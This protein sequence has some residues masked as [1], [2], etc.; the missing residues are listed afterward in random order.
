MGAAHRDAQGCWV[1][2]DG[3]W[4]WDGR[5][6]QPVAT[7]SRPVTGVDPSPPS[8][9]HLT[10]LEALITA[11]GT[12]VAAGQSAPP[13][14]I[15]PAWQ[16]VSTDGGSVSLAPLESVTQRA[17]ALRQTATELTD[18]ATSLQSNAERC[19]SQAGAQ[20]AGRST[21]WSPPAQLGA[22]IDEALAAAAAIAKAEE[23]LA[24]AKAAQASA[25]FFA[26]RHLHHEESELE[27]SEARD[28]TS[29]QPV[30]AQIG[31]QAPPVTLPEADRLRAQ[32]SAFEQPVVSIDTQVG[33][34]TSQ[35]AALEQ[36][37]ERRQ[38]A[39][40]SL[41]FDAPYEAAR[42]ATTGPT[43][44]ESQLILK[45]GEKSYLSTPARLARMVTRTQYVGGSSGV[46]IPI[47]HTGIRYRVGSF[48]GH[49]VQSQSLKTL[50]S[51][52]LILTN[53]RVAYV[54]STK[55]VAT[56]LSKIMHVA[57][58]TD[59]LSIA[60]EGRENSDWYLTDD[61][62]HFVFLLNWFLEHGSAGAG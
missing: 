51:G 56:P 30:L 61:P 33:S 54:G 41:G 48:H 25:G 29:V 34:A 12:Q 15:Q 38:Q 10:V 24:S 8:E 37:A 23:D 4:W 3:Q 52:V 6:W 36:E 27:S 44:I 46:S 50:D 39:I 18:Q 53:Q 58:Y 9:H 17:A 20:L 32:A 14:A 5:A 28:R 22:A 26:K 45:A 55:S 13:A 49:P 35:A 42:L 2:D 59:G 19:W 47:G 40:K 62:H 7:V 31:R 16:T 60:R 1:S 11:V 57:V 43:P 21:E